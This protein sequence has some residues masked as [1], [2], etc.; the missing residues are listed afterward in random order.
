MEIESTGG[1]FNIH[2]AANEIL[3]EGEPQ[4]DS[5]SE[6][7]VEG[8]AD[9]SQENTT[10][11]K[12]ASPEEILKQVAEQKES[13][14]QF[15]EILKG[16]NSLGM[17][18]NGL[19]IAVDSP[20]QLKE[21]IQKGFDYTQKTMEHAEMVKAKSE[22]FA[23]KEAQYKEVESKLAQ[24]EQEISDV[25]FQNQI[26]GTI[27]S[28]MQAEDPELFSHLDALYRR[29]ENSYVAQRPLQAKF[30]GEIKKLEAQIQN[31]HGQKHSEELGKIKQGWEKE[32]SDVQ[33]ELA[34]PLAKLGIKPDY[35][36][37][38]EI[39]SSDVTNSMSVKQALLAAYGQEILK[40]NESQKKLLETK[41]KTKSAMIN[42]T[43]VGAGQRGKDVTV[44]A[45][46][47]DYESL[48]REYSATM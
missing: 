35:N 21:L 37:V 17:I 13:P 29:E 47:G 1:E 44:K 11:S 2:E 30:E 34:A 22:E 12:E 8:Q 43:G 31:I 18:R 28:K 19:P 5:A 14:E 16:V 41:A 24:K 45:P 20:E 3:A 6:T 42:R 40:A 7:P 32:L 46:V 10:E 33:S 25:I 38:K 26:L 48:L 39:W 4:A 9:A 36:K 15:A 23:Q 27:L